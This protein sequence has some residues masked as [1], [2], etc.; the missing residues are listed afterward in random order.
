LRAVG[1]AVAI[2]AHAYWNYSVINF[3]D[4]AIRIDTLYIL[5]S[6]V[7]II[8][9]LQFSLLTENRILRKELAEEAENGLIPSTHLQYLPYSS[10]RKFLGW[11]PP[12]IDRKQY[13]ELATQLAFR[14]YQSKHC[15]AK[16][17]DTYQAEVNAL[18]SRIAELLNEEQQSL[19]SILY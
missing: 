3:S 8:L 13:I 18:R 10:K 16:E 17:R 9:I 7:I 11:L 15:D 5:L 14:K 6:L 12:S 19:A 1:V 4:S 2:A